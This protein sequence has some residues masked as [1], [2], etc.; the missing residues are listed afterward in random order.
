LPQEDL[1]RYDVDLSERRVT[2]GFVELM[3]FEI[4]RCREL[5]RAAEPGIAMLPGRS[6]RCIR[7]AHNLYARILDRIEGQSYDVF[8]SRASVTTPTKLAVVGRGL[9]G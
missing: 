3:R 2:P 8:S 7:A 1:R 9:I 5:Y 6:A 4:A